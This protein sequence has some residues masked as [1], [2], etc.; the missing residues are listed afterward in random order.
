M[1]QPSIEYSLFSNYF[2][3]SIINKSMRSVIV[4]IILFLS[5][6]PFCVSVVHIYRV[7]DDVALEA[8]VEA[9]H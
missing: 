1:H 4:P 3:L 6:F 8:C 2:L 9:R 5:L 7:G